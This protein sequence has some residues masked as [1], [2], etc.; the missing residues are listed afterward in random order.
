LV[1]LPA[2]AG[3]KD[4]LLEAVRAWA[5]RQKLA[6]LPESW[7]FAC[8]SSGVAGLPAPVFSAAF[9]RG[10]VGLRALGLA[11]AER[12]GEPIRPASLLVSAGP[13]PAGLA[14][15]RASLGALGQ[16]LASN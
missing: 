2:P 10:E 5:H 8:G 11:P 1:A 7:S 13:E 14:G 3:A 15:L 6:I 12:A 4:R 9:P 16:P